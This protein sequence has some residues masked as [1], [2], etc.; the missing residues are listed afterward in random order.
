MARAV[1]VTG[2]TGWYY[3]ILEEGVAEPGE[4]LVLEARAQPD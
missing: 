3:R 1:Q 2:R 4:A